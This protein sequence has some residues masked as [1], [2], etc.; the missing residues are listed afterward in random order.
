[1]HIAT[2]RL[3]FVAVCIATVA[4]M[5]SMLVL[6]LLNALSASARLSQLFPDFN[7]LLQVNPITVASIA[8]M[9]VAV[10]RITLSR[11]I[12]IE[13]GCI[14][15]EIESL[16]ACAVLGMPLRSIE[17]QTKAEAEIMI[18]DIKCVSELVADLRV[19]LPSVITVPILVIALVWLSPW[20]SL[21]LSIVIISF[22]LTMRWRFNL[23]GERDTRLSK[24]KH[25]YLIA[26]WDSLG[27]AREIRLGSAIRLSIQKRFNDLTNSDRTAEARESILLGLS[28]TTG[29]V[30]IAG[31]ALGL[32]W[33]VSSGRLEA[34]LGGTY[35]AVILL[36]LPAMM[37]TSAFLARLSEAMQAHKRIVAVISGNIDEPPTGKYLGAIPEKIIFRNFVPRIING[38]WKNAPLNFELMRGSA[39]YIVGDNGVGK[40]TA[41]KSIAGLYDSHFGEA[42]AVWPNGQQAPLSDSARRDLFSGLFAEG[43]VPLP[44]ACS[45]SVHK[46]V[47]MVGMSD[48]LLL[49]GGWNDITTFSVGE[50]RRVDLALVLAEERT[51]FVLDESMANQSS[52]FKDFFYST[53]VPRLTAAGKALLIATHDEALIPAGAGVI[54]LDIKKVHVSMTS[55]LYK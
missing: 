42:I 3:K 7:L 49:N 40:S 14:R 41:L 39:I 36:L 44:Q 32:T 11:V 46:A 50:R 21:A 37:T 38:A 31:F 48:R 18:A 2:S 27:A 20:L 8:L 12:Q 34:G 47:N 51:F 53:L 15:R 16:N 23:V 54:K 55:S 30:L 43:S 19:F 29:F 13:A 4:A 9:I 5:E 28:E 1:M 52:E 35:C 24:H 6:L 45:K 22:A 17:H 33:F 26:F 25:N 10:L